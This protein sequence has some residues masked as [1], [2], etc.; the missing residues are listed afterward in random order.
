GWG[1]K[2]RIT[3]NTGA[4][5][6]TYNFS[7]RDPYFLDT[8]LS[9]GFKVYYNVSRKTA[10]RSYQYER[11]GLAFPFGYQLAEYITLL[12]T[13]RLEELETFS[14]SSRTASSIQGLFGKRITSSNTTNLIWDTRDN[15]LLA[16]KGHRLNTSIEYAGGAL[17]GDNYFVK[18][19]D[20]FSFH[21]TLFWKLVFSSNSKVGFVGSFAGRKVPL[22]ERFFM[23]GAKTVRGY[24]IGAI[25]PKT[26][27]DTLG[28]N[29]MILF[30]EEIRIPI[31]HPIYLVLFYDAGNA[32]AVSD[33][34][35]FSDLRQGTGVGAR[36]M[37]PMA[38]IRL[39]W[40]YKIGRKPG[41]SAYEWHFSMGSY[42]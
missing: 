19:V 41:E 26:G 14:K 39:D 24:K 23:G 3:F 5:N 36:F 27:R 28:G 17:G 7:Y 38:P 9:G 30:N 10:F 40:G 2:A 37:T 4:I 34:I 15:R 11:R 18:T 22:A 32:F 29:K 33:D 42:F 31:Q 25:G 13:Y 6:T 20:S 1:K 35:D 8:M 21:Q 12:D 16:T